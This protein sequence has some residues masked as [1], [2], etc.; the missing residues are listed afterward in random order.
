MTHFKKFSPITLLIWIFWVCWLSSM[1][2]NV[3]CSQLMLQFDC[4]QLQ[5][6]YQTLEHGLG[7]N[8]QHKTLQTTSLK[9]FYCYS[10]IIVPIFLL[11]PSPPS[12]PPTV[13]RVRGSFIHVLW[14]VPSPFH[15]Y[16]PSS[17]PL[18]AVSLFHVSKPLVLFCLLAYFVH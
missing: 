15:H 17:S 12:P 3:D 8:L 16:L 6:V 14:L 10:I 18:A 9:K 2:C 7:G 13:V 1:W 11:C 4:Y 5:L